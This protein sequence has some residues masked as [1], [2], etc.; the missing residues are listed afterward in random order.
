MGMLG[1]GWGDGSCVPAV[2]QELQRDAGGGRRWS[3]KEGQRGEVGENQ[4]A[5][6][7]PFRASLWAEE[8]KV[9]LHGEVE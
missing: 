2:S 6:D 8:R 7:D 5:E 1:W 3:G 9:G 4:Q